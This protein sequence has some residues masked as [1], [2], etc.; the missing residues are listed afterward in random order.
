MSNLTTFG[1]DPNDNTP[2]RTSLYGS[3]GWW[4]LPTGWYTWTDENRQVW[5][6]PNESREPRYACKMDYDFTLKFFDMYRNRQAG[7]A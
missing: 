1:V 4:S 2:Q 3:S 7:I 5:C 6:S